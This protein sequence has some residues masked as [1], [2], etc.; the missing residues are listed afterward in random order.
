MSQVDDDVIAPPAPSP[1]PASDP[2]V[3]RVLR[4]ALIEQGT[5]GLSDEL[6]AASIAPDPPTAFIPPSS[7]IAG[8]VVVLRRQRPVD[9]DRPPSSFEVIRRE[10]FPGCVVL[11]R[12]EPGIGAAFGSN[13][14]LQAAACRAQALVTDGP[15]RD[16]GRLH[17][18]GIPLGG[19]GADPTRPAGCPMVPVPRDD[20]FGLSW[21]TGDWFLRDADGVMRLDDD[22]ARRAAARITESAGG[23]LAALLGIATGKR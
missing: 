8:R 16:T 11:V 1:V 6:G 10:A 22:T 20:L 15:W 4:W 2:L 18:V 14:A 12:C 13:V 7:A 17:A 21:N 23:E 9:G 3:E 5:A 19:N